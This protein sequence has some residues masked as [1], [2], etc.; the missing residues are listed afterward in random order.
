MEFVK[1]LVFHTIPFQALGSA[2]LERALLASERSLLRTWSSC[3][4]PRRCSSMRMT[5]CAFFTITSRYSGE[6]VWVLLT[7]KQK[8][9]VS[10]SGFLTRAGKDELTN[11][12]KVADNAEKTQGTNLKINTNYLQTSLTSYLKMK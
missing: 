10:T 6:Q 11:L 3:S 12:H 8:A 4:C 2:R 1:V 9:F 7:G 5:R